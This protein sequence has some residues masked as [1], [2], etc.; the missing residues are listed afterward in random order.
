MRRIIRN[1]L[2][3]WFVRLIRAKVLEYKNKEKFLRI[4][5]MTKVSDCSFGIYTTL[6]DEIFLKNV[7]IGDFTY[8]ASKTH[9]HQTKIGKFCSIGPGCRIGLGKHPTSRFVSTHPAFFS[10]SKQS[11]VTFVDRNYFTEFENIN[12]GNDVWIGANVLVIDGVN[13]GSGAI[14]AAGSVVTKDVPPYAVV[15]GVPAKV[16]KFRFEEDEVEK[17]LKVK[18]WDMD[19]EYFKKYYK[20]F[21][22]VKKII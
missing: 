11:Q 17:L 12:I 5:Y 16:I 8:V 13:I 14:I 19:I 22:D 21:L 1:P 10:I 9:I 2:T 18:W 20:R 4:G 15:G 6:Y 3:V 7:S